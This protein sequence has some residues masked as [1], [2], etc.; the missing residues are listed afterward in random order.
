MFAVEI[1][2]SQRLMKLEFSR[3]V[4]SEEA[5]LCLE[6][7][8]MLLEDMRPGFQLLMDLSRLERMELE[9]FHDIERIMKLLNGKGIKE[10]VRVIPDPRKDIGF[11]IMSAFHYDHDVGIT[12]CD[13]LDDAMKL[14]SL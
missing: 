14:L 9:C 3:V 12:T 11:S 13:T 7:I 5:K 8:E 2:K 6:R 10:V 4:T 1:D